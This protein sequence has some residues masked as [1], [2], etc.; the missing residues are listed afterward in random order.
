V[1]RADAVLL[2]ANVVYATSYVA[3]RVVLE[4]VPPATLALARLL[5]AALILVPLARGA[6][7]APALGPGERWRVA[8]MGVSGFAAAFAFGHWGLVHS[9]ATNGALLIVVEPLTLLLLGPALLGERLT[10][11]ERAGAACALAGAALVVVNGIPGVTERLVPHWRGD[12]LLVL[13][14]VAFASYSLLGRPL[15]ARHG[16]LPLTAKSIV[17]GIPAMLPLAALEWAQGGR[18]VWTSAAVAGT[19]YLAVVITALGY[20]IWNWALERVTA[21]R[22]GVFVNLQPVAG[23]ALGVALLGEPLTLFTVVG[24]G[25]VTL[26]LALTVKTSAAR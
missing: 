10:P 9:T 19:L 18:A 8:G 21:A 20:L 5:L 16:A 3:T 15:L 14:G 7:P 26:G 13:S 17:W 25:L 6:R 23:A 24:A 22:A 12:V 2:V 4:T 11:R 1:Q